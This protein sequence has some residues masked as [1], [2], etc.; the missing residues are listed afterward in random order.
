MSPIGFP[1]LDM[2]TIRE[3]C[4]FSFQHK[5]NRKQLSRCWQKRTECEVNTVIMKSC[6]ANFVLVFLCSAFLTLYVQSQLVENLPFTSS[7]PATIREP[8]M[9]GVSAPLKSCHN[10]TSRHSSY[11]KLDLCLRDV[12]LTSTS[13]GHLLGLGDLRLDG[14]FAEIL[15]RESFD[16]VYAENRVRLD[17]GKSSG[18]YHDLSIFSFSM[19]SLLLQCLSFTYGRIACCHHSPR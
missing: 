17:D 8:V 3:R 14:L 2:R 11:L 16:G 12:L 7:P 9:T 5:R 4:I 13:A 1:G 10:A 19:S 6:A 18:H 15:K